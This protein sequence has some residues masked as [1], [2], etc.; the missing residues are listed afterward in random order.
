MAANFE[1]HCRNGQ[2]FW[3]DTQVS[4]KGINWFG[5][6]TA[7]FALHGLWCVVRRVHTDSAMPTSRA[8]IPLHAHIPS[9]AMNHDTLL[10]IAIYHLF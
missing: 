2:I 10:S 4:I 8:S 7:D 5:L 3:G 9:S 6:E 1:L